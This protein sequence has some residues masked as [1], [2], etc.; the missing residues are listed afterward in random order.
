MEHGAVVDSATVNYDPQN[1]VLKSF[2]YV[3]NVFSGVEGDSTG[4]G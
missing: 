3:K 1:S 4:M 2:S